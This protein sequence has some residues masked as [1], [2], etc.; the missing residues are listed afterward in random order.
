MAEAHPVGFRWVMKAKE[1][2]A[3]VIHVDPHFSRT[4]ALAD[5]FAQIRAGSDIAFLGGLIHHIIET[6]SYFKEYVVNYTNA[7]T[8]INKDFKDTEDLEGYFS[9][10]DP[11]TGSYDR[12]SWMYEG[13]EVAAAAGQREHSTQAFSDRTGAGMMMGN[14]KSDETL[15]DP[16]CVFQLL[17]KHYSRYTPQMVEE[18]CGV[19][20][21]TFLEIADT[22]I[23]NSGR[24][25][26]GMLVYAVGWTQ[27]STGVQMIRAGAIVQLLLGNV[28]RPGGGVM[29]M[30]GHTSIQGSSD[31]PTLYDLLPGYLPMPRAREGEVTLR[32][33]VDRG[34]SA[35]G[36]WANF[37]KYIVSLCK[38]Y[39][40]EGA[41]PENDF[42]FP[43]LPKISGNHS[44]F[45]TMLRAMDGGLD[46]LFVMGQNPAVG[47]QHA[48]LQRRALGAALHAPPRQARARSLRRL[49][50]R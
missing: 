24:E 34:G 47:S 30:R 14:V 4:S 46:G 42:G 32:D 11:E 20:R 29:A 39:F 36:W 9:G 2:G 13:G 40:G 5:Q 25:R 10:Y 35:R 50:S 22:L 49:E 48:G 31:I 23:A 6:E 19:P 7:A 18:V 26:T 15:Q 16:R 21:E 3:K 17:K 45:S 33:Y 1:R 28:G 44:H 27:H 37:E 12:S 41:T 43:W 8:I 38:A